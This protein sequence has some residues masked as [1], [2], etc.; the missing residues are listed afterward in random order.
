MAHEPR[1][2]EFYGRK[3]SLLACGIEWLEDRSMR[4]TAMPGGQSEA[5]RVADDQAEARTYPDLSD[6]PFF[7][8]IACPVCGNAKL[9]SVF[10]IT[11]GQLKQKTSLDY[12]NIGVGPDTQFNIDECPQCRFVLANPRVMLEYES[13]VYNESKSGSGE[14]ESNVEKHAAASALRRRRLSSLPTLLRLIS[15]ANSKSQI[16]LLDVGAGYGHTLSLARELGI[17]GYGIEI[18]RSRLSHC[19]QLGLKVFAPD[20]FDNQYPGLQ[21]D[22]IVA[23]SI[24]EHA[25]DLD[26]FM[27]SVADRAKPGAVIF[28]NGLTPEK[29]RIERKRNVFVK[30]HFIEHINYFPISTLD[31]FMERHGFHALGKHLLLVNGRSYTLPGPISAVANFVRNRRAQG[32]FARFYRRGGPTS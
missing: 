3:D 7:E 24:I 27:A 4:M 17:D 23:Q 31:R 21:V 22:L 6:N 26:G 14:P 12:A 20:E 28:V 5:Q 19:R 10:K 15:L 18:D 25:V 13:R 11:Y 30:A 32:N 29:I 9:K 1:V 8:R 2:I 16:T